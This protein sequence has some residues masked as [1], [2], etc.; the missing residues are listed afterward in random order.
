M[1]KDDGVSVEFSGVHG[2]VEKPRRA[3]ETYAK[4]Q[5]VERESF[6]KKPAPKSS[7]PGAALIDL[8][9]QRLTERGMTPRELSDELGI[10]Y[11][12]L[13]MLARGERLPSEM[14][15]PTLK[16]FAGF[17]SVPVAQAALLAEILTP[18]DFYLQLTLEERIEQVYAAFKKD[19]KFGGFAP[20][21]NVWRDLPIEAK[22]AIAVLYENGTQT[23]LLDVA[24]LVRV[25]DPV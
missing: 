13:M 1:A 2:A 20:T 15:I 21:V 16:K 22:L 25:K 11:V 19:P 9:W 17:I 7:F 24:K 4:Q 18:D 10:T 12:Y 3:K 23:R 8:T 14:S 5:G 6:V